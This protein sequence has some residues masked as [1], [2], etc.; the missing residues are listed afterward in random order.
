M[1]I[2]RIWANISDT[3]ATLS[4]AIGGQARCRLLNRELGARIAS[5][6]SFG[7]LQEN[8]LAPSIAP[9]PGMADT[10]EKWTSE[11]ILRNQIYNLQ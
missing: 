7:E 2:F 11:T 8:I 5:P 1:F 10:N 9:E 3:I 6:N 4:G